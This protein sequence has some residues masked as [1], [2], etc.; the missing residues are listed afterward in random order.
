MTFI[1]KQHLLSFVIFLVAGCILSYIL[2]GKLVSFFLMVVIILSFFLYIGNNKPLT[3]LKW[4]IILIFYHGVLLVIISK[5]DFSPYLNLV[6]SWKEFFLLCFLIMIF[7]NKRKFNTLSLRKIIRTDV[8]LCIVGFTLLSAIYILGNP[9]LIAGLYGFRNYAFGFLF[10]IA[11]ISISY[12]EDERYSFLQTVFNFLTI[13]CVWG[14]IQAKLLG[15]RYIMNYAHFGKEVLP[16]NFYISYFWGIQRVTG[17]FSD[18]NAFAIMANFAALFYSNQIFILNVKKPITYFKLALVLISIVLSFS[19]SAWIGLLVGYFVLFV[20]YLFGMKMVDKL[21]KKRV[22]FVI[23]A[24]IIALPILFSVFLKVTNIKALEMV[25]KHI[26][27]TLTLK[28]PSVVGHIKSLKSSFLFFLGH[29]LGMGTGMSGPKTAL[30]TSNIMNSES[31]YFIIAFDLGIIGIALY[32]ALI[33]SIIKN[34]FA[35]LKKGTQ[36]QKA[37]TIFLLAVSLNVWVIYLFLPIIHSLEH[38]YLYYL[39]LG[40]FF[41]ERANEEVTLST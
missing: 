8:D 15:P 28:D 14:I 30:F 23:I 11:A 3:A 17:V 40:M 18:P 20:Y 31:S 32:F 10:Y 19:R 35:N 6:K 41:N 27:N 1:Y 2:A 38:V 7:I 4:L 5:S 36:K 34:L 24:I 29:P 13:I 9:N 22:V 26:I 16:F 12:N 21:S 37:F 25:Q 39:L 33:I